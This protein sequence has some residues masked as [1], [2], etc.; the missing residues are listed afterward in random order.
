MNHIY[1]V[2]F[3]KAT[4]TFMAVAEYAKSHSGG[5]SSSTT[6][7]VGSSPVIR[8]TR[9]ATLAILAITVMFN[10][11]IPAAA[12]TGS[13]AVSQSSG[14]NN[15]DTHTDTTINAHAEGHYAVAV[16]KSS[17]A[18]G[19]QSIAIGGGSGQLAGAKALGE[20]SIAIGGN[21]M[22]DGDASIAIGSDDLYIVDKNKKVSSEILKLIKKHPELQDIRNNTRYQRTEAKGHASIAV[23][24]MSKASGHFAN[25]F[26][27]RAEAEGAFSVA[28]GL[29]SRA[30][31]ESSVALGSA[32]K[33]EGK[34][35]IAIGSQTNAAGLDSIAIGGDNTNIVAVGNK[36]TSGRTNSENYRD[37][38]GTYLHNNNNNKYTKATDGA[39]AIGTQAF[40][41]GAWSNALG[42][43]ARA[44]GFGSTAIGTGSY[45]Q[46]GSS[47]ALG[48]GAQATNNRSVAI[49][50][51]SIAN[52]V[53]ANYNDL[54]TAYDPSGNLTT[55]HKNTAN[56]GVVSVGRDTANNVI[57]RRIT[58]VG[59]GASDTD[60]VNVI[61]L[62]G[63]E[64]N[65]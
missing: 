51:G 55:E 64:K 63:V 59:A 60:A 30:T 50:A 6:G 33:A 13:V 54:I 27:T 40:G 38:V 43:R 24:T 45:A 18:K 56:Y 36:Q 14:A 10:S 46:G 3:N 44:Q 1:K 19:S 8:L 23:G 35:A 2:I 28:V 22:A 42:V 65:R 34:Q 4:G 26:G 16:G 11:T 21:V 61:Q 49:G 37:I 32:S 15:S 17:H 29:T 48:L 31:G 25:A 57:R 47:V 41:G 39:I 20:E 58:N 5:S 12:G 7:Q 9:V 62:K 53:G 52:S